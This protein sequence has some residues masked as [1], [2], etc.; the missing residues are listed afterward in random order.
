MRKIFLLISLILFV[1]GCEATYSIKI[2]DDTFYE[3]VE[4]YTTDLDNINNPLD[5]YGSLSM[6]EMFDLQSYYPAYFNDSNYNPYES[7]KQN[8]VNYY[9]QV[10]IN[11]HNQYGIKYDYQFGF[12]D[13]FRSRA[14][15]TCYKEF[16]IAESNDIYSITTNNKARCFDNYK[17]LD[18]VTIILEID[19]KLLYSNADYVNNNLYY[20]YITRENYKNKSIKLSYTT[21]TTDLE[22]NEQDNQNKNP[23]YDD[24]TNNEDE[25]NLDIFEYVLIAAIILLFFVGVFGL[26]KFKSINKN[27]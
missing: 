10:R 13:I 1:T 23:I 19:N 22:Y 16:N 18:K 27:D 2:D 20:W 26:I 11:N 25:D 7:E 5:D 9:N 21:S 17:L 24:Q 15:N 3:N 4:I 6:K 12:E 14:I 8:N